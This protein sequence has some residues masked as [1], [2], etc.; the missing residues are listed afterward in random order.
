M[1]FLLFMFWLIYLSIGNFFLIWNYFFFENLNFN[2]KD[3]VNCFSGMIGIINIS[4]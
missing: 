1:M 2:I 3:I 4:F